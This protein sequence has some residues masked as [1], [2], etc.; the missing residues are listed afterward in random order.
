MSAA[1]ARDH[2]FRLMSGLALWAGLRSGRTRRLMS[3]CFEN[4]RTSASRPP[5]SSATPR[6]GCV[7]F[8]LQWSRRSLSLCR[9]H[10]S[11]ACRRSDR[12]ENVRALA[13]RVNIRLRVSRHDLEL[14]GHDLSTSGM[15]RRRSTPSKRGS[16]IPAFEFSSDSLE[17]RTWPTGCS[18]IQ[19]PKLAHRP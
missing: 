13:R 1:S 14:R 4:S 18:T 9:S 10:R 2:T 6:R 17:H 16:A 12:I 11:G 15:V 19:P 8:E 3:S 5:F 7:R